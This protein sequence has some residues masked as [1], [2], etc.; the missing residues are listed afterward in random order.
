MAQSFDGGMNTKIAAQG[1]EGQHGG[2]KLHVG[3]GGEIPR[4]IE[5]IEN[6][7]CVSIGNQHTPVTF[8][9][10]AR[11]QRGV[12]AFLKSRDVWAREIFLWQR[13][14]PYAL[15]EESAAQTQRQ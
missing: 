14:R 2:E 8:S 9:R 10:T 15:G 6:F 12:R 13:G 3:R 7:T 1:S 5:G 4:R 11:Q